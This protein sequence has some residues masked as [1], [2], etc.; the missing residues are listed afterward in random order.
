MSEALLLLKTQLY[1]Y[2]SLNELFHPQ[3][4]KQSTVAI[5]AV[6]IITLLAFLSG[7]NALTAMALVNMGQQALIPT[8]MV[9]VSSFLTLIFTLLRSNGI[10]LGSRDFEMLSA[11]P[12]K[13]KKIIAS[14]FGFLYLLNFLL[15]ILFLLPGGIVWQI[16][17]PDNLRYFFL[18]LFSMPF[19]PLIPMCIASLTGVALATLSAK[20][21]RK[22]LFSLI[23]SFAALGALLA[24][25]IYSM[26]SGKEGGSLGAI[27]LEQVSRLY[28]LAICF[29]YQDLSSIIEMFSF[30]WPLSLL[31]LDL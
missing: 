20:F 5:T 22:N 4:K 26:Q 10:L 15:V 19:I 21:H 29:R 16:H 13:T 2:F 7:Y 3:Q 8:Y 1:N 27:L 14:K 11:L 30:G 28:P 17:T 6:G 25:G 24:V 23:F 31:L 18:Y 12:I 9:S